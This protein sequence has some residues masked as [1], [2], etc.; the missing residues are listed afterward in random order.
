[1]LGCILKGP[2]TPLGLSFPTNSFRMLFCQVC[3]SFRTMGT[4]AE[5][6]LQSS[7]FCF[8]LASLLKSVPFKLSEPGRLKVQLF[9]TPWRTWLWYLVSAIVLANS[10]FQI[11]SFF[12]TVHAQGLTSGT[13][14]H[15]F[16][17]FIASVAMLFFVPTLLMP[18]RAAAMIN[19]LDFLNDLSQRKGTYVLNTLI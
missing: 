3:C 13:A 7:V 4:V 11:L 10:L 9:Q 2:V 6:T 14:I 8:R 18:E 16:Y 12:W 15:M 5:L 19:Q 1:M 17:V